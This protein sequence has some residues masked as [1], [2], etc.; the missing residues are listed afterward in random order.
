MSDSDIRRAIVGKLTDEG[1]MDEEGLISY[2][3]D[4]LQVDSEDVRRVL[5]S[6]VQDGVLS[7]DSSRISLAR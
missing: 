6:G 1:D 4:E 3:A 7:K 5:E 2:V